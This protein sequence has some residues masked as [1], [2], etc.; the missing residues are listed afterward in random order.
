MRIKAARAACRFPSIYRML[1]A[2]EVHL[3]AVAMLAPFLTSENHRKLLGKARGKR[4]HEIDALVAQLRPAAPEPGDR[5][6][7]LPDPAQALR[8]LADAGVE[9][10]LEALP[11][12][13]FGIPG[14][15]AHAAQ[16]QSSPG[17][18]LSSPSLGNDSAFGAVRRVFTFV[19][20]GVVHEWFLQARDLLRHKFPDGRMGD[21]IGEALRRLVE[22]EMP[23]RRKRRRSATRPADPRARRIPQWLQDE[24]WRRDAGRCSYVGP[25]GIQCGET[26]WLE[27]D[28]IV[29]W[30]RGG[31]SDDPSNIRLLC[32]AH[33]QVEA[34]RMFCRP[35]TKHPPG[36]AT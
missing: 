7:A 35:Y 3:T 26:A 1:R 12:L 9:P 10:A 31:R 13:A 19:G 8:P 22:A 20:S 17:G 18:P 16:A 15:G 32:R 23:G 2:G 33:N 36:A 25:T 5:I 24:V 11:G 21:I 30:A 14:E 29:P 27:F 4:K 34:R 6:R 28:H